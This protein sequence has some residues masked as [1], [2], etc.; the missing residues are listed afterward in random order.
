LFNLLATSFLWKSITNSDRKTQ[1]PT[2]L[3]DG[4]CYPHARCFWE[5]L[6][7][8]CALHSV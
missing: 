3:S 7:L 5:P 1:T 8:F 4:S 6:A 2:Y